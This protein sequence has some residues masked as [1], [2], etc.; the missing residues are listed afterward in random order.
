M[1][2]SNLIALSLADRWT[3]FWQGSI[4]VWIL[5]RGVPIGLY[6]IGG[7][8]AARF[9]NWLRAASRAAHRRRVPGNR[10]AG[11]HGERQ[12]PP[13]RRFGDLLGVGRA[14]LRHRDDADHRRS[15]PSRS[16]RW[17]RPP[18]CWAPPSVS[19]RSALSR[20]CSQGSSSSPRS[21][22][23]SATW[24][25]SPSPVSRCPRRARWRTSPFASPSCAPARARCSPSPTVRSSRR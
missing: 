3:G 17:S 12:A 25:R 14:A 1:T 8:L 18:R 24:Y 7:L 16:D 22:T 19:A 6:L 13:G 21:S 5:E 9:I 4:G 15:S 10:P 2:N 20:T 11:A 23:A